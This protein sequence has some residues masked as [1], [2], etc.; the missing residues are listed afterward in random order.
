MRVLIRCCILML[1]LGAAL[2]PGRGATDAVLSAD[3]FL[4]LPLRMHLLRAKAAPDLDSRLTPADAERILGKIN[5]IWRQAGI[6]FFAEGVLIEEAA[7]QELYVGLGEN[8]TEG[9][10]RTIRP[11]ES[12]SAE[13]VHLYY[14]RRMRPNGICLNGS[15]ELLFV[16]DTAQ[17][18][19]VPGGIDEPLPRVSAH[20]I[21][22]AL[23]LPHRQDMTNLM[24]S[25]TTGTLLN[26]AEISISR[27]VAT[28]FRWHLTPAAA[29]ALAERHRAEQKA[30]T[31]RALYAALA[32]LPGGD[33]ARAA[34]GRLEAEGS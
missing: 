11:R 5:G 21:G 2:S 9:H 28:S 32:Q 8:R 20:E 33:V 31:A 18:S 6:Q 26:E 12:Q 14:V 4:I 24:A 34:R 13:V 17:L 10:L 16:K 15:P 3:E 25:G 1:A 22:H 29:L 19:R 27:R 7:N 30:A 23:G